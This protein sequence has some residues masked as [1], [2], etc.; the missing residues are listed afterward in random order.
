LQFSDVEKVINAQLPPAAKQ[1]RTWWA[2]DSSPRARAQIWLDA[3]WRVSNLSITDQRVTF[4]RMVEREKAYVQFFSQLLTEF[5]PKAPFKVADASPQGTSWLIV[6]Y[7]GR[8]SQG[9]NSASIGFAFT[10]GNRFRAE[11]YIDAGD[12]VVN[13]RLFDELKSQEREIE[14]K[15]GDRLSWERMEDRRASRIAAYHVG[16]IQDSPGELKGLQTWA[17]DAM[18]RLYSALNAPLQKAVDKVTVL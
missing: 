3:G 11:F 5:K 13:K 16:A 7:T 1:Y 9:L 10:R 14:G 12:Q 18:V 17:V 6:A 15:F 4:V 8:N 2:N